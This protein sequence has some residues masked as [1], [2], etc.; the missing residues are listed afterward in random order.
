MRIPEFTFRSIYNS[1]PEYEYTRIHIPAQIQQ[2]TRIYIPVQIQ[3]YTRIWAYQNSSSSPNTIV[4]EYE[5]TRIHIPVQIQ[6]IV[7][8]NMLNEFMLR[9]E[10][11]SPSRK[12][13]LRP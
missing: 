3:Q 5:Y 10:I 7:I 2:Y 11:L 4:Y 13:R 1:I 12:V 8:R 6:K 9:N